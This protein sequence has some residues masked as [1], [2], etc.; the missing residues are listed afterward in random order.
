MITY[1][2][3]IHL[4]SGEVILITENQAE[5]IKKAIMNGAEWIPVGQE[6][7]NSKAIAKVGMHHATSEQKKMTENMIEMELIKDGRNDL[8][9][10]KRKLVETKT[11]KHA[12]NK[13]RDFMSRV[14][15]GD[16]KALATYYHMPDPPM[17]EE[18]NAQ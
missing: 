12:I 5:A 6:L 15:S 4:M 13:R 16:P 1:T 11:I 9:E 10:A 2:H 7:V 17:L 3:K 18:K 8:V 14:E